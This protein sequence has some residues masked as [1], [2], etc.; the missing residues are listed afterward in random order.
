LRLGTAIVESGLAKRTQDGGGPAR[1][2]F[3]MEMARHDDIWRNDLAY[4]PALA[5]L[6]RGK[7]TVERYVEDCR[8]VMG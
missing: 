6:V 2:L 5:A 3:Q 8:A 7:G 4:R 1:G